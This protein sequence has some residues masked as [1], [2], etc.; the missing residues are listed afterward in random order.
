MVQEVQYRYWSKRRHSIISLEL[1]RSIYCIL[2]INVWRN[3]VWFQWVLELCVL[4]KNKMDDKITKL[5]SNSRFKLGYCG[6]ISNTALSVRS[7]L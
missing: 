3:E 7:C 6:S 5:E 4:Y 1:M 2:F